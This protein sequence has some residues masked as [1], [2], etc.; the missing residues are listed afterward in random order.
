MQIRKYSGGALLT[1][2]PHISTNNVS[3]SNNANSNEGSAEDKIQK[4]FFEIIGEYGL[5]N[6]K[7]KFLSY[8]SKLLTASQTI[9]LSGKTQDNITKRDL[10]KLHSL[11]NQLKEN[12]EAHAEAKTKIREENSGSDIALTNTGGM[13]AINAETGK[14]TVVSPTEYH[15]NSDKYQLLTNTDLL[16][17][18]EDSPSLAFDTSI[19]NNLEGTVGM[20]TITEY[21][22]KTIKDFGT[23]SYQS[24]GSQYIAN[25]KSI[26]NGMAQILGGAAP[27]G[28]Y[29]VSSSESVSDQGYTN[30]NENEMFR[31]VQ[32]IWST[33][34]G[35]MKNTLRAT[36]AAEGLDPNNTL[37]VFRILIDAVQLHTT[38]GRTS[39]SEI[40]YDSGASKAA[41]LNGV[42]GSEKQVPDS[43]GNYIQKNMGQYISNELVLDGSNINF[44]LP[45]YHYNNIIDSS[46]GQVTTN[47]MTGDETYRNMVGHGIIDTSKK[48]YFGDIP[49]SNISISGKG[50]L[51]DQRRGGRVVYMPV[52]SNQNIDFDMLNLMNDIQNDIVNNNINDPVKQQI[53]WEENGFD[54]DP[55]AKTG[56][57]KG[58]TL[59]RYW[60]Q[61]AVTS[62]QADIID[63]RMLKNSI[64][65]NKVEDEIAEGMELIYNSDPN[66][67]KK[68]KIDI[69]PGWT[70]TAYQSMLL[71][72]MN[73]EQD[74]ALL[75]GGIAYTNRP[76]VDIVNAYQQSVQRGNGY[77][78]NRALN[79]ISSYDLD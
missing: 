50:F 23:T 72:P 46:T 34:N 48:I 16:D 67:N 6:D 5:R 66:N 52:D 11:A 40:S 9:T 41:G 20:K 12:S 7:D 65:I 68:P 42:T 4:E 15:N 3:Q 53:I 73:Y 45:S 8:A 44:N 33:L 29:K 76:N 51:V 61:P 56:V 55:N 79:G 2:T 59:M 75:A 14:L 22:V 31:A 19:L 25:N 62:T 1:Y 58:Y 21:I 78:A 70:D 37:D 54:Y 47:I 36:A 35:N 38:H 77:G 71:M 10:I 60:A 30:G 13:Y 69:A 74:E 49:I 32:Y 26:E 63:N 17:L 28:I 39:S 64:F 27:E 24:S 57:P 43:F 18:R